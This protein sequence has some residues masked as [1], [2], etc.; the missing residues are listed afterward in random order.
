MPTPSSI[1]STSAALMNDAAQTQYTN[2]ACLPY[3]NLA[4]TI[5]Q[6]TFELNSLPVTH[7]TSTTL[8]VPIGTASVGYYTTPALPADLIEIEQLWESDH[9][10]NKWVP[11]HKEDFIPQ[12]LLDGTGISRFGVWAWKNQ[13]IELV[14]ANAIIDLKIDYIAKLFQPV[15]IGTINVDLLANNIESFLEFETAAFCALFIAEN[16]TRATT[17]AGLAVDSL[18]RSLGIQIKPTQSIITRR[19]PFRAAFKLRRSI[20]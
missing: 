15:T 5:L 3:L 19:R 1:I 10:L 4:I 6:E 11:V 9:G 8:A 2:T 12:Y 14:P 20:H 18:Q 7:K 13:F 17:L 16:E